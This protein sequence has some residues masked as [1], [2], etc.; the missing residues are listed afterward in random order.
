M[1]NKEIETP[2]GFCANDKLKR[3]YPFTVFCRVCQMII[4]SYR[5]RFLYEYYVNEG[6]N[7]DDFEEFC[8]KFVSENLAL[9]K[10]EMASEA[11]TRSIKEKRFNFV[12]KLS[13]LGEILFYQL[14]SNVFE[15]E[16]KMYF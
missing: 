16:K 10:V 1:S 7:P 5:I 8:R 2:N 11:I 4:K 3:K 9:V 6:P 14:S 15:I 12:N 13:S